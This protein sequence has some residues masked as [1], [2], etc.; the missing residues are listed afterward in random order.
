MT[1]EQNVPAAKPRPDESP[2][3]PYHLGVALGLSTATY[4]VTLAAVTCLQVADDR[5]LLAE[6]EPTTMRSNC[7]PT[8]T[9][10]W[11]GRSR[12]LASNTSRRRTDTER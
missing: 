8:T 9:R 5:A 3:R 7:W 6:R 1:S 4:A 12:P 11:S 10:A 2:R